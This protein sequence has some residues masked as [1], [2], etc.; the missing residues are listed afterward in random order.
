MAKIVPSH[1]TIKLTGQQ[2]ATIPAEKFAWVP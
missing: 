1:Q 2:E